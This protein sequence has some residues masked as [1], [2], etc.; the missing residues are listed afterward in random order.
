MN[1]YN[2]KSRNSQHSGAFGAASNVQKN[3]S[4]TPEKMPNSESTGSG[5]Q[6]NSASIGSGAQTE[7][8]YQ[9]PQKPSIPTWSGSNGF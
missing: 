5:N 6:F 4:T 2:P 7:R 9:D 8:H 1:Q 3:S